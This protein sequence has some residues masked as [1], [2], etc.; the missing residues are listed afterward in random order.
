MLAMSEENRTPTSQLV[1]VG[2]VHH[3]GGSADEREDNSQSQFLDRRLSSSEVDTRIYAIV[4]P[5]AMQL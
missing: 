3:L 5:F 2:D 1:E 4:A